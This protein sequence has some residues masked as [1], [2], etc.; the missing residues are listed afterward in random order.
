MKID[1]SSANEYFS[2]RLDS[3]LWFELE[4]KQKLA[5]IM[6][7]NENIK[8]LPFIGSKLSPEQE[9][10]FP[11]YYK[12]QVIQLPDDVIK[13]IFEEAYSL[14]IKSQSGLNNL[15]EGIQSVSL[16]SASISF[17]GS[18]NLQAINPT[19]KKFLD[20]WIKKGFDIE[21]GKFREVY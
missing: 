1:I 2:T 7:A 4:D 18:V 6:T 21:A 19:S 3:E 11:R 16:G 12:G 14:L 10:I 20:N 9:E 15:P 17:G 13:G 5:A 8:Y